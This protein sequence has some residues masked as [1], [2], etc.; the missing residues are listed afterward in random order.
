MVH[1]PGVAG[2]NASVKEGVPTATYRRQGGCDA[3]EDA[4]HILWQGGQLCCAAAF[5]IP[6]RCV[7]SPLIL[8]S[9]LTMS[10]LM[11]SVW[12]GLVVCAPDVLAWHLTCFIVNAAHALYLAWQALPPRLPNELRGLYDRLFLPY[13]VGKKRF[14]TIVRAAEIM[15][16]DGDHK[17]AVEGVSPADQKVSILLSGK[18]QV[19]CEDVLLHYIQPFE[20]IDSP[21][22]ESCPIGSDK[23]FQVSITAQEPC[24]YLCWSR[25]RLHNVLRLNPT[26]A[27]ILHNLVGRDIALKLYSLAEFHQLGADGP[28][29]KEPPDWW[30]QTIP[31]SLSADAVYTGPKGRL[32]SLAWRASANG[33][34]N[35]ALTKALLPR[36][37]T[38]TQATAMY[39]AGNAAGQSSLSACQ[40]PIQRSSIVRIG[41]NGKVA[42][43]VLPQDIAE[44]SL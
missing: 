21:E 37:S 18:L 39:R 6:H 7:A 11:T 15:S 31:R 8:R 20:F 38:K 30:R 35:D 42:A 4:Q 43:S 3:W 19:T 12:A 27:A 23:M 2:A 24:R 13:Q 1:H 25:R 14:A 16:L 10:F 36:R 41:R 5:L 32:R 40:Q 33:D 44:T 26:M 9:L 29:I 34:T 22:Y 17:Y 28:R